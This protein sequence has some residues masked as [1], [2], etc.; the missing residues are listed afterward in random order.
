MMKFQRQVYDNTIIHTDDAL[1]KKTEAVANFVFPGLT[2]DR[3]NITGYYGIDGINTVKNQIKIMGTKLNNILGKEFFNKDNADDIIKIDSDGKTITGKILQMPYLK[4]FSTKFYK[5]LKKLDRLVWGKKGAKTAF[6]YSNLVRVGI[7]MFQQILLTNGYLE[8]QA[9]STNYQIKNNTVCYYCGKTY[10]EHRGTQTGGYNEEDDNGD[11]D[12]DSENDYDIN[13]DEPITESDDDNDNDNEQTLYDVNK[14]KV[15]SKKTLDKGLKIEKIHKIE[16]S[17]SSTEYKKQPMNELPSHKFYPAT[18]ISVTGASNEDVVDNIDDDKKKIL[19]SVFNIMENRQG[20]YIKFVLGSKVMNEGISLYNVGEVHILDAY[21]T[22]G[23]IDQVIGRAIRYCSHY[24]LMS[25]E[26]PYPEVNVYK[27]VVAVEEGLST[28]EDLYRKAEEKYILT[29]KVERVIKESAIDCPININGNIFAEELEIYKDC[30]PNGQGDDMCPMVC[31]FTKCDYTCDNAKL[32]AEYYDPTRQLYRELK[33]T[34]LDYTTFTHGFAKTEIDYAKSKIK[35]M[36]VTGY[37]FS[38]DD[39]VLYVKNFYVE[40]KKDLFDEFF[41]FKALDELTPEKSTDFN[42]FKDVIVDKYNNNGY[43]IFRKDQYIFQPID[44]NE[45]IPMRYRIKYSKKIQ[46]KLSLFDFLHNIND[47]NDKNIL[48]DENK[49]STSDTIIFKDNVDIYDFNSTLDYYDNRKEFKYVGIIDKEVTRK[50][51]KRVEDIKDVFKIREKR[52]KVLDK[53]RGTGIPSLKGAVCFTSKDRQYLMDI[54]KLVGANIEKSQTRS[55]ICDLIREKMLELE[56][57]GTE[58]DKN[59]LTYV[60]IPFNH[61]KHPF[62]YNLEDR[63][64]Y[65]VNKLKEKIRFKINIKIDKKGDKKP[66]YLIEIK[67]SNNV[68]EYISLVK[69]IGGTIRNNVINVIVK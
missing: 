67:C 36:F 58:K 16:K 25:E 30:K 28:D 9:S 45:D 26:T 35:D 15:S 69:E 52:G 31:D 44:K 8:Y 62:P 27:Y 14:T 21:Y 68:E 54:A 12:S 51:N 32:N 40:H 50:K 23:R 59:K 3:K 6:I 10:S 47:K 38:L 20:K 42:N 63:V 24:K 37:S 61:P 22:L 39:I 53:K 65:I 56:K 64:E 4:N 49:N 33:I 41:V 17:D 7:D 29:K 55:S 19:E 48:S 43:L 11:I 46:N 13:E 57:Y 34:E 66:E 2:S 18:F 1:D 60:I 5:A